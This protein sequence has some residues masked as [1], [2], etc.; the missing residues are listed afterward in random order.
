MKNGIII[1]SLSSKNLIKLL[2]NP[3][4]LFLFF[5]F[6]FQAIDI[7]KDSATV[8]GIPLKE[9]SLEYNSYFNHIHYILFICFITMTMLA[10]L[11]KQIIIPSRSIQFIIFVFSFII[12]GFVSGLFGDNLLRFVLLETANFLVYFT[13][14]FFIS[15]T[16]KKDVWKVILYSLLIYMI[17][18]LLKMY[19]AF[20]IDFYLNITYL[21]INVKGNFILMP[22][23]FLSF[24]ILQVERS[25]KNVMFFIVVFISI[26]LAGMRGFYVAIAVSS[27]YYI[28]NAKFQMSIKK[29]IIMI[30]FM[31]LFM[32]FFMMITELPILKLAGFYGNTVEQGVNFR[33]TQFNLLIDEFC[34]NPLFGRGFGLVLYDFEGFNI[35][36]PKPYLQ[37][38]EW[39]NFL[40]KTGIIGII[41]IIIAMIS[42]IKW[43][44]KVAEKAPLIK[45]KAIIHG[46][47]TGLISMILASFT[48]T[49][50]S[51]FYFHIYVFALVGII[52]SIDYES[53]FQ[54]Y[55][56]KL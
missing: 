40:A 43:A 24:S 14:P 35:D 49:L 27:I 26:I 10:L 54:V 44:N 3:P 17:I 41:F 8:F 22:F 11:S 48:N 9:L 1:D 46:L 12:L 50:F 53:K 28:R 30:C 4:I 52:S 13:I 31:F 38:L 21:K 19:S 15:L 34:K 55:T 37:E 5:I 47:T 20:I 32:I 16:W 56:N 39:V 6:F 36:L 7:S 51:S 45:Q 33:L 2:I 42:L 25:K 29:I 18:I 23:F